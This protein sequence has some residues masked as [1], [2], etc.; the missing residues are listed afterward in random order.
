MRQG[1]S[2]QHSAMLADLDRLI[3][4]VSNSTVRESAAILHMA[5][6]DM[7]TRVYGI[8]EGE[9]RELSSALEHTLLS[10]RA[11]GKAAKC[12]YPRRH[13]ERPAMPR[14]ERKS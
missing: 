1:I 14:S 4:D 2:E 9:L 5:R 6:L 3:A 12:A 10:Q 13:C 8:S 11:V 7:Q